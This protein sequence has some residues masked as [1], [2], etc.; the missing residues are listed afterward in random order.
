VPRLLDDEEVARRIERLRGWKKEGSFIAKTFEFG[1]F[2]QGMGFVNRVAKIAE[3]EEH[4]PDIHIRYTQVKLSIQTHSAGGI[5]AWDLALA[6][7]IDEMQA[8]EKR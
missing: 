1:S 7:R 6:K 8:P 3:E 4:H 5:T 2:L